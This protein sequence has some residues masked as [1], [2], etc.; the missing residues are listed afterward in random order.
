MMN[1]LVWI[2]L[3]IGSSVGMVGWCCFVMDVW[4]EMKRNVTSKTNSH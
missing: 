4:K 1:D 2:V 3:I